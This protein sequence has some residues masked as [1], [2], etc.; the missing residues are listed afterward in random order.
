[1]QLK[2][3][4]SNYLLQNA[5]DC[6]Q[7]LH[8]TTSFFIATQAFSYHHIFPTF[9]NS[10]TF[11]LPTLLLLVPLP[12]LY[13]YNILNPKSFFSALSFHFPSLIFPPLLLLFSFFL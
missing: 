4:E 12:L 2:K 1:M 6:K 5:W 3:N 8:I 7:E 13:A 9:I 11:L 10:L